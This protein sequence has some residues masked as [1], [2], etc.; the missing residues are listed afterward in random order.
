MSE[1]KSFFR[2]IP[3]TIKRP[4]IDQIISREDFDKLEKQKVQSAPP[5]FKGHAGTT[6][7]YSPKFF[8]V[9]VSLE[10]QPDVYA[11][12]VCT[13]EP[14]FGM[15]RI[16]GIFAQDIEELI[17]GEKIGFK[18]KRLDVFGI[19]NEVDAFTYL[20]ANG[21][22][23]SKTDDPTKVKITFKTNKNIKKPWW[24]FW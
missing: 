19:N 11:K 21:L 7:W 20:T 4:S 3:L 2:I 14:K 15:D 23:V 10:N 22:S 17:F 1:E 24:K 9:Q 18:T 6:I 5:A 8:I 16:D 13:F 12:S